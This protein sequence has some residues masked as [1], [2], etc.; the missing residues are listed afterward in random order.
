MNKEGEVVMGA[1]SPVRQLLPEPEGEEVGV[2]LE[3]W[4]QTYTPLPSP[5]TQLA[6][7]GR[8]RR[9]ESAHTPGLLTWGAARQATPSIRIGSWRRAWAGL[10]VGQ[11]QQE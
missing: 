2:G 7:C 10:M 1:G 4:A 5:S 11:R 6:A 8:S 3:G 9:E